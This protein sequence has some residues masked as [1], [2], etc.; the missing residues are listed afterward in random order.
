R[1]GE[2]TFHVPEV[3]HP[4][5]GSRDH[6]PRGSARSAPRFAATTGKPGRGTQGP[7]RPCVEAPD[8]LRTPC[9][10]DEGPRGETRTLGEVVLGSRGPHDT[11][12]G[13]R[14]PRG[15]GPRPRADRREARARKDPRSEER[16]GCGSTARGTGP[17]EGHESCAP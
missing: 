6:R 8:G 17:P 4:G 13:S 3:R 2:G 10:G 15:R 12:Q 1:A 5:E 7:R 11:A 9:E 14:G 16:R